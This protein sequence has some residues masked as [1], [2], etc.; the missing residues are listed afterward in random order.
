MGENGSPQ[1]DGR[2]VAYGKELRMKLI[3]IYEL[4]NPTFFPIFAPR[5]RWTQD[6]SVS[7]PGRKKLI[8]SKILLIMFLTKFF[9]QNSFNFPRHKADRCEE[10]LILHK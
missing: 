8:L 7:P 1:P 2:I 10:L 6:R 5:S 3:N 9:S 4:A